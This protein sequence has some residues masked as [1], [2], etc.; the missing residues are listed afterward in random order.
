MKLKEYTLEVL[1][2]LGNYEN[3]K[4]T[5]T[6]TCEKGEEPDYQQLRDI[7]EAQYEAIYKTKKEAPKAKAP[8]TTSTHKKEVL[9]YGS[10]TCKKIEERLKGNT[11][12]IEQVTKYYDVNETIL[13]AWKLQS[14]L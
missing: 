12:T 10:E 3:V 13:A 4:F 9:V 1:K 7:I 6:A 5:L 14:I 8:A 11:A 2:N